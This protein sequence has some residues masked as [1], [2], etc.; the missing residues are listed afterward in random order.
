MKYKNVE[1]EILEL[2]ESIE[3]I[4]NELD[5]LHQEVNIFESV[6]DLVWEIEKTYNSYKD[7]LPYL[8]EVLN[9]VKFD[10][11]DSLMKYFLTTSKIDRKSLLLDGS[12]NLKYFV[13]LNDE[14][15]GLKKENEVIQD[16]IK[17]NESIDKIHKELSK[18]LKELED[19][20]EKLTKEIARCNLTISDYNENKDKSESRLVELNTI[21]E[22]FKE[23][24]KFLEKYN[25]VKS[26]FDNTEKVLLE[27]SD[28]ATVVSE[29]KEEKDSY[30]KQLPLIESALDKVKI[31]ISKLK[32]YTDR[33]K[34]LEDNYEKTSCIKDALNP[35]KGIPV[36]FIENYL[37][38]TKFI[39]NNLLDISQNG[40]F[41]IAFEVTDKDFFI[42]VYKNNGDILSDI[43]QA[44]QGETALTSLSLSLAL[45]E[46]SMKKY[47]IFLLD[48]LD[49]ALDTTNRRSFIDMV[50]T[51]MKV[52]NSE[53]VFI[54][55]HNNEFE[56]IPIDMIL[57]KDNG[58]D[59]NNKDFMSNKTVLFKV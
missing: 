53:Q 13:S 17:A 32:E 55:S 23:E 21:L 22:Y 44:S 52:L 14:I 38:K 35:T 3:T 18:E 59:E 25:E 33:K 47:N 42:K 9:D 43:S 27:I 45:I 30:S 2:T 50:Q 49:G 39:T 7:G 46:Q 5:T 20:K 24:K 12:E 29:Q 51:Q 40:K 28:L 36:Y 8:N 56:N 41:A 11:F 16:K 1:N 54:I 48:E 6:K 26:N 37:D 31:K 58:I 4:D 10:S 19:K 15:S 57:L 34:T